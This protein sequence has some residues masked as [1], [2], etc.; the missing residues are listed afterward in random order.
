MQQ[1]GL[2]ANDFYKE[3]LNDHGCQQSK[4]VLGLW[5]HDWRPIQFM[6]VVDTFEVKYIG[7]E[8]VPHLKHVLELYYKVMND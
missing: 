3:H 4:L 1:V 2:L 6:L 8:H 7:K 5:K